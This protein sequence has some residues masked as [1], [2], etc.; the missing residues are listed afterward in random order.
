MVNVI[1]IESR[2]Q[3]RFKIEGTYQI[4]PASGIVNVKGSVR[5][6]RKV[7]QL[8]VSFG[9]VSGDFVCS[10][11]MLETLAGSPQRV[12]K[13]Y[14]CGG[15]Q[16]T[17]L[18][19]GP[20]WVGQDFYCVDNHLTNLSYAPMHV[21][22]NFSC[23]KNPIT[24]LEGIPEKLNGEFEITYSAKLPLLRSIVAEQVELRPKETFGS[25]KKLFQIGDILNKY[26]GQGKKAALLCAADLIRAGFKD[27]ARW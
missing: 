20:T 13:R 17:S 9:K 19:G 23:V 21:G 24:S 18:Q 2:L 5:L 16:L 10:S 3:K 27:N 6:L 26:A 7:K 22:G 15:N 8:G 14:Y 11:S 1:D 12:G 25:Y 4:D